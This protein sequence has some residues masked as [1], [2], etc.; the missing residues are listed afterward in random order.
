MRQ[1]LFWATVEGAIKYG[2][3]QIRP[4][5]VAAYKSGGRGT[6]SS[7]FGVALHTTLKALAISRSPKQRRNLIN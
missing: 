3:D 6:P 7:Y 2:D 4:A 5:Y 1:V